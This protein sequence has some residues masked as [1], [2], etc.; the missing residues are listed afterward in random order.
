MNRRRLLPLVLLPLTGSLVLYCAEKPPVRPGDAFFGPT[1]LIAPAETSSDS[2]A[3]S[4][5]SGGSSGIPYPAQ[6]TAPP[7]VPPPE[8]QGNSVKLDP[9]MVID[10]FGYRPTLAKVAVLVKR[11][12]GWASGEN[13]G[14][15]ATLEVRKWSNGTTVFKGPRV[16]WRGG[17]VDERAGDSGS[18]FDFSSL[19]EPGTYY[20]FDPKNARRSHPFEIADDVYRRVLKTA[21][22]MFYFNR[23]NFAKKPPYSCV[24][25]RCWSLGA[26]YLGPGQDK[27][28]R[29]VR[30][31]NDGKTARDLS[32]GWW[33][34]GDTN[35][36]VT[37]SAGAVHPLLT[38][39]E[40]HP[41]AFKDDLDIPE[42]GNGTPDLIDEVLIEVAWLEKMQ[43][44][45]LKGGALLKVGIV[46][47][48]EPIPDES[49][50]KRFYYPEPC[51]SATIALAGEFA[52]TAL[53]LNKLSGHAEQVER[54]TKRA[55]SA[56]A[57]YSDHPK[58]DSCDDG[59]IKSGDA[60]VQVVDQ[61]RNAVVAAVYLF[62]LTGEAIYDDFVKKNYASTRPF[63]EDRWS[64]YEPTQG[65]ALLQYAALPNADPA[66]KSAI[67]GRKKTLA[68][69]VDIFQFKPELDLY[70]AFMRADSYHWGSNVARAGYGNTNYDMVAYGLASDANR[71]SFVE[72]AA[73]MLHSFHGV[74]PMQ[75]VYLTNMYA[76]GG[77]ACADETFHAWFRDKDPRFD[78]ARSSS[79]GPAPGYLT[80]GPNKQYCAGQ[81]LACASSPIKDQPPEKAYLDSNTGWEPN[82]QYSSS[83]ELTESGIYYQA[84]YV[85][86]LSKFV[87]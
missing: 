44:S 4:S 72:R 8:G 22:R 43:P 45:D 66:A 77:D 70:R 86:L 73:G 58:S 65:D 5:K 27:E 33:D 2:T 16:A 30:E 41:A 68:N 55:K 56:W 60:D 75:L 83:W 21:T 74:N 84:A 23:A 42:S 67:L 71:G 62:A 37:F 12:V 40:E 59:T 15:G 78:N 28:A 46:D 9:Q 48:G 61:E 51:S 26:D 14:F 31:R 19:R 11:E 47:Y 6:P 52:H 39:F 57:F 29:N 79:L 3:S 85:R 80:G 54:L 1:Q 63:Q 7:P 10:Q 87:D 36:Y 49:R 34:A 13:L 24:G 76:D 25:K 17:A 81:Q 69:S 32:G 38:A 18:W 50:L 20:V 53:V 82:N 64:V 35:K